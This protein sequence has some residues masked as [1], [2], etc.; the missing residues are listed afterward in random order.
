VLKLA[1][2]AGIVTLTTVYA[3][4]HALG[5]DKSFVATISTNVNAPVAIRERV[6]SFGYPIQASAHTA[7]R[8]V[9]VEQ[10][11]VDLKHEPYEGEDISFSGALAPKITTGTWKSTL[12]VLATAGA[13][14]TGL[15]SRLSRK[16]RSLPQDPMG[17]AVASQ[18]SNQ[19]KRSGVAMATL[20]SQ[21][22]AAVGRP[23]PDFKMV[24]GHGAPHSL[25]D[26]RGEYVVI[27]F[28]PAGQATPF[29]SFSARYTD[30]LGLGA[31][32]I[33]VTNSAETYHV[34][35]HRFP[36]LQDSDYSICRQ[37][38]MLTD[39]GEIAQ[40]FF[41]IDKEG[42]VQHSARSN[43]VTQHIVDDC[44][45]MLQG[46]QY[47]QSGLS[48]SVEADVGHAL[49]GAKASD[50]LHVKPS[51]D[52]SKLVARAGPLKQETV[53]V[54]LLNLGGPDT[55]DDVE[56]FLYNL[57]S[58]PEIF[59][60]PTQMRWLNK[61]LAFIIAK[62]RARTSKEGYKAIGGG[63]PQLTTTIKQ[64]EAIEAALAKQGLRARCYV[65]MRYWEPFTSTAIAQMKADGIRNLVVLPLYPQFSISTSG[66]SLRLLEKYFYE[67]QEFNEMKTTV[68]PAWYN[69]Q[70][71]IAAMADTIAAECNKFD[72]PTAPTI[73]FS[74]HGVPKS[75]VKDLGD[76]YVEQMEACVRFIMEDL[77]E[78][79]Y[80][81]PH[82]VAYQSRV[83]PVEWVTPY[84]DDKLRELGEQGIKKL[85]VVPISFVQEH[86]ET[87]EEID[88]EYRELAQEC[89]ITE[90]QRVPA[91]GLNERFIDDLAA[92]VVEAMPQLVLPG[93]RAINEGNAVSLRIVNDLVNL[94]KKEEL[95]LVPESLKMW[96]VT[97]TAELI[98]GRAAMVTLAAA[99]LWGGLQGKVLELVSD[100]RF[101][102]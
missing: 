82:A 89:G 93:G 43:I 98:N 32:V 37:Y 54:L 56:P 41:I 77:K 17:I 20:M 96:G 86:I 47:G 34:Q 78:R 8:Q 39:D 26:Y 18:S 19:Y 92:A 67:D 35:Q 102:N 90:W 75:Y 74:A 65:A 72:D 69:R 73:F 84:T 28:Y 21:K 48:Q 85:V 94:Y 101:F 60:L 57:F 38:G 71:Y 22:V 80:S 31:E 4:V 63:S 81:N 87:L 33:G 49:A 46:L 97:P 40:G 15:W 24:V 64:G 5:T 62:V 76:P 7:Q 79:G 25:L 29:H 16:A 91:L 12:L 58:D 23:A 3:F 2:I 1:G 66:S 42:V 9:N 13:L 55:L 11:D 83:G 44:I 14:V 50:I 88:M 53:G 99:T 36:V 10:W 45:S 100:P 68:I 70:G 95:R 51:V 61:P 52:I 6:I 59:S 27:L 30:V